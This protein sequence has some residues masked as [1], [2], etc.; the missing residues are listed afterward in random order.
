MCEFLQLRVLQS[1]ELAWLVGA[2]NAD[3]L[4]VLGF[5]GDSSHG[6]AND[7]TS[8]DSINQS[9]SREATNSIKH[10]GIPISFFGKYQ[11]ENYGWLDDE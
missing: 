4:F 2:D 3:L 10:N 9:S 11:L 5:V 8:S 7:S 1:C 6:A